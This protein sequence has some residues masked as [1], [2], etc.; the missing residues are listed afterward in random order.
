MQANSFLDRVKIYV[1]A[2]KGGDGCLSFRR[3]KFIE[4]GGPNG[5]NGGKGGDVILK[6]EP[7]L[8]TLQELAYNPHIEAASGEKGGTNNKFGLG[9]KDKIIL[10]PLGTVVKQDGNI[11]ADLTLPSQEVIVARGGR[12]GRGNQSFKTHSNTAPRIA[13]NGQPGQE[14]TLILELKVLADV[15]LVG[16]PNAGKSTFLKAV[17]AARPKIADYPFTTLNPNLGICS[18]KNKSFVIADIPGIIEGAS[19]GKGL[20]HQFLKHIERT[21]VLLHLVDPQGFDGIDAVK[22]VK[23][24]EKELKN[25]SKE[26]AEKPRMIVINKADIDGAQKVFEKIQKKYAKLQVMLMS[27]AAGIGINKALDEIIKILSKN[28]VIISKKKSKT[29]VLHTVD[30]MFSIVHLD[31]KRVQISGKRIEELIAM[32]NFAQEEAVERLRKTFKKIGLEKALLKQGVEDGS[33]I[34]VN[35]REFEWNGSFDDEI[36][37]MPDRIGGYSARESKA[38]RLAKRKARRDKKRGAYL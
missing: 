25:F 26:L 1:K 27:A 38:Q 36:T 16:F 14:I 20:G 8:T 6:A 33:V 31:G 32:T 19:E 17:S 4:F 9:A 30:P 12:G 15:G 2:G 37:N 18:H 7:N 22:S 21:R 3:E 29:A 35:G 13:E 11:I 34:V 28:P 10:V 5:G 24:I 23:L